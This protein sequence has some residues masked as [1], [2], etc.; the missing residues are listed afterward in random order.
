MPRSRR[1]RPAATPDEI[2]RSV[3]P[4]LRALANALRAIVKD[5]VPD[6][7][8]LLTSGGRLVRYAVFTPGEALPRAAIERLLRTVVTAEAIR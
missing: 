5:A 2:L 1:T 4:A 7:D 3:G 8:A 6:P